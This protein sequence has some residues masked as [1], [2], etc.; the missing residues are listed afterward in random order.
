MGGFVSVYNF[1][2]EQLDWNAHSIKVI[3]VIHEA[4]KAADVEF[5]FVEAAFDQ[6][7]QNAYYRYT[8]NFDDEV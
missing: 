6:L 7:Y 4:A 5:D 2:L 3:E 1:P 8:T